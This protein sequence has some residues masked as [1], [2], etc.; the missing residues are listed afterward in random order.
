MTKTTDLTRPSLDAVRQ[1]I[2]N[3]DAHLVDLI[4]RRQALAT[5]VAAAK[6]P[7]P[8]RLCLRPAR[9]RQVMGRLSRLGLAPPALIEGV[10][11]QLMGH[12]LQVQEPLRLVVHAPNHPVEV[13]DAARRRFGGAPPLEAATSASAAI[14]A[15]ATSAAVAVIEHHALSNWW[16]ALLDQPAL[17]IFDVLRGDYGEIRALWS[18]AWDRRTLSAQPSRCSRWRPRRGEG[19]NPSPPVETLGLFALSA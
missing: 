3:L 9:E 6:R 17:R 8:G 4:A 5:E 13:T 15:A 16:T 14:A 1:Q 7:E 19:L 12:S 18:G 10:W 2:D 11:G